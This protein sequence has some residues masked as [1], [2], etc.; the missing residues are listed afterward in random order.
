MLAKPPGFSG[1]FAAYLPVFDFAYGQCIEAFIESPRLEACRPPPLSNDDFRS[2]VSLAQIGEVGGRQIV[3]A[4][5]LTG[6]KF[7]VFSLVSDANQHYDYV[8]AT[9]RLK[10]NTD[11][12]A[13][14]SVSFRDGL[15]CVGGACSKLIQWADGRLLEFDSKTGDLRAWWVEER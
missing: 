15:H 7:V 14:E 11:G 2:I 3:E 5:M 12:I 10:M 4:A 6:K 9:Q 13:R 1:H 8:A